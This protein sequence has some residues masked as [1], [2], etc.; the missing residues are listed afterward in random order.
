MED[1]MQAKAKK[2]NHG[3]RTRKGPCA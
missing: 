2:W 3:S 1:G